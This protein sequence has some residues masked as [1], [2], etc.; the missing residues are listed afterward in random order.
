MKIYYT[1]LY[2]KYNFCGISRL[3]FVYK[4]YFFYVGRDVYKNGR[5]SGG[6]ERQDSFSIRGATTYIFAR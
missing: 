4:M 1:L 2:M 5:L 3:T 6:P